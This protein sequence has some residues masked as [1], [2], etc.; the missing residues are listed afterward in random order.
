MRAQ[1]WLPALRSVGSCVDVA[2]GSTAIVEAAAG[3][4]MSMLI[5][6]GLYGVLHIRFYISVLADSKDTSKPSPR[7]PVKPRRDGSDTRG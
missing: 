2:G 6:A 5:A 1:A 3:L 7:T 4:L